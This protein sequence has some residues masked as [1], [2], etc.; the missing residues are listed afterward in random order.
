[1]ELDRLPFSVYVSDFEGQEYRGLEVESLAEFLRQRDPVAFSYR[2]YGFGP[3]H[4][5]S[6]LTGISSC[7]LHCIGFSILFSIRACFCLLF[8]NG[9]VEW[10]I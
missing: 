9:F 5:V 1:M 3:G 2:R 8:V 6:P 4:A 10:F 7:S